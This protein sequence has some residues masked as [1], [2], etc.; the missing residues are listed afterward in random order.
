LSG[1][2]KELYGTDLLMAQIPN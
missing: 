1:E 2:S